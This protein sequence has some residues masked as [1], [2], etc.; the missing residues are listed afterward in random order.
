MSDF[1]DSFIQRAHQSG[2]E[3]EEYKIDLLANHYQFMVKWNKTHNLTR[4]VS[5][6]EAIEK[7][8]LDC[9]IGFNFVNPDV[10]IHDLGSGAGFPGLVGAILRPEQR[11]TLIEP[12]RKRTS[13]LNQIRTQLNLKNVEVV[14]ARAESLSGILCTISRGTFS[15]PNYRPLLDPLC[16]GGFS[17]L[18]IGQT[19]SKEEYFHTLTQ[20]GYNVAWESYDLGSSGTRQIGIATKGQS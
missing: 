18:W 2:I 10:H 3:L 4:I 5:I 8:Y 6:Q 1:K 16:A 19:P 11:Y 15:W 13:F 17:Y 20:E 9:I 14:Q 12:A 7:H